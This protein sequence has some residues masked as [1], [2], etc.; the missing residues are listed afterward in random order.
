MLPTYVHLHIVCLFA[1]LDVCLSSF[2]PSHPTLQVLALSEGISMS[3]RVIPNELHN[4]VLQLYSWGDVSKRTELI[5][6]RISEHCTP[7]L[8]TRFR[9]YVHCSGA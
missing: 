5:Y 1:G 6:D 3:R 2:M 8:A 9:R 7:S 4:R